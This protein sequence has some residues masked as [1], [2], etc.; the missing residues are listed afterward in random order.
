[1]DIVLTAFATIA[2]ILAIAWA[3]KKIGEYSLNIRA[4]R[5]AEKY[6]DTTKQMNGIVY[7]ES[8]GKLEADQITITPF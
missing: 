3:I 4:L 8:T 6:P 2:A 7:N 1:M 5:H